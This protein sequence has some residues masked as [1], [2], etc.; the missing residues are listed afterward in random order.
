MRACT[1]A[2]LRPLILAG[3]PAT[4]LGLAPLY[5]VPAMDPSRAESCHA[6]L[7][8]LLR[9]HGRRVDYD[10]LLGLSG[11]AFRIDWRRDL[12]WCPSALQVYLNDPFETLAGCLGVRF[13]RRFGQPFPKALE[14]VRKQ[15]VLGRP[16]LTSGLRGRAEWGIVVQVGSLTWQAGRHYDDPPNPTVRLAVRTQEDP[17]EEYSRVEA[18]RWWGYHPGPPQRELWVATPLA[19]IEDIGQAPDP[20]RLVKPALQRAVRMGHAPASPSFQRGNAAFDA[21]VAALRDDAENADLPPMEAARRAWDNSFMAWRLAAARRSAVAF[22]AHQAELV[23]EDAAVRLMALAGR[24]YEGAAELFETLSLAFDDE[25]G[26]AS[27]ERFIAPA[28]RREAAELLMQTQRREKTAQA[29]LLRAVRR[30]G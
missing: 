3:A 6:A 8:S 9:F 4:D 13:S 19:W 1:K 7:V 25:Q 14:L 5:G 2:L 15:L 27:W 10:D 11:A 29:Y 26:E 21:W 17:V 20:A 28:A 18:T 30:L 16:V 23:D 24:E 12:W 22:L